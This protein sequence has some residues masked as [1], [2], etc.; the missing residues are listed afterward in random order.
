MR[1][2]VLLAAGG[3]ALG[4]ATLFLPHRE[5]FDLGLLIAAVALSGAIT[6]GL[7]VDALSEVW[8]RWGDVLAVI[9]VA[10]VVAATGG[11]GSVYQDLFLLPLLAAAALR[12][13]RHVLGIVALTVVALLTPFAYDDVAGTGPYLTDLVV[14]AGT[15][16]LAAGVVARQASHHRR[17]EREA[18]ANE[19]R[20]RQLA[21]HAQDGIYRL[22]LQPDVR[23]AYVNPAMEELT[24]F[25][26]EAFYEDPSL[27]LRRVHPDDRELVRRSRTEPLRLPDTVEVRWRHADGHWVWHALREAAVQEGGELT[28]IQGIVRDITPQ[29]IREEE[30]ELDLA[31]E[32]EAAEDLRQLDAA[33]T[34]TL[35]AVAHDLRS[36]LMSITGFS[37]IL[38]DRPDLSREE[39]AHLSDRIVAAA[40]RLERILNALLELEQLTATGTAVARDPVQLDHLVGTVVGEVD[41]PGHELTIDAVPVTVTGDRT[42]IERAID[43]L[44]R[45]AVHHTPEGTRIRVAVDPDGNGACVTIE[46][47]G[48]GVP[49]RVKETIFAPFE[50]GESTATGT[51][52]GLSLVR[53]IAELHGGRAWVEDS[54]AGGARFVLYL[55]G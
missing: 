20:F 21:E 51:G 43:N 19:E 16:V 40:E 12:S 7:R 18:R 3:L 49:D 23:F 14:D 2:R 9:T 48:P 27:P 25:S 29:K 45:N 37:K 17:Q 24:G 33:K 5:P 55:P 54:D 39:A 28:A 4:L 50:R 38:R 6:V 46:D 41:A 44:V 22:E 30:L 47:D 35:R 36:P 26:P 53:A 10:L 52:I 1:F 11:A 42:K 32:Q 13:M 15:W 8:E 34:T 31:R